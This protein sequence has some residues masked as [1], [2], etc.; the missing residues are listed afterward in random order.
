MVAPA[1]SLIS[2]PS[3]KIGSSSVSFSPVSART[4]LILLNDSMSADELCSPAD[5]LLARQVALIGRPVL[6]P[7][8]DQPQ[9]PDQLLEAWI[10]TERQQL[11][12]PD[13]GKKETQRL[14]RQRVL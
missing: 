4:A 8:V 11:R 14:W 6:L 7:V 12:N 3:V 10:L 9:A 5:E 13:P 1:A 2:L